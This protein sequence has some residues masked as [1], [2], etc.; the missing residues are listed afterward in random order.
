[1]RFSLFK[2]PEH[3]IFDYSPLYYD[4]HKER[5]EK[6]REEYEQQ[7][8]KDVEEKLKEYKFRE[9]MRSEWK[10]T[11]VNHSKGTFFRVVIIA[12]VLVAITYF[13]IA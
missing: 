10:H 12:S 4:E 2:K 11:S 1:M 13:L 8:K 3:R 9:K 5:L 7:G 6:L